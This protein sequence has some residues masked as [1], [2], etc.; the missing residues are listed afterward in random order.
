M[1]YRH[2]LY[3]YWKYLFLLACDC[4]SSAICDWTY[5]FNLK[6]IPPLTQILERFKSQ[7]SRNNLEAVLKY[8]PF[9][10][11]QDLKAEL[12]T[13]CRTRPGTGTKIVLYNLRRYQPY[14]SSS[15]HSSFSL[16][17]LHSLPPPQLLPVSP[18]SSLVPLSPHLP[19]PFSFC[20]SFSSSSFSSFA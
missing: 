12:K 16:S 18:S 11:E 20:S 14:S 10:T 2:T 13:L 7:E 9:R 6:K 15:S 8:S 17:S 1:R 19:S 5:C 4:F 3:K